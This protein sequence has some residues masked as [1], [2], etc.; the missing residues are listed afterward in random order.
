MRFNTHLDERGKYTQEII[1][2]I[3]ASRNIAHPKTFMNPTKRHLLPLDSLPNVDKA[4]RTIFDGIGKGKRFTVLFDCDLDGVSSGTIITR[5]LRQFGANINTVI[6]PKKLHGVHDINA[7]RD[8]EIL[9]IVDSLDG[10]INN[11]RKLKDLG[12]EII[13]MDHHAVNPEIP[14][15]DVVTLVTSQTTYKN[16]ELSGA[17]VVWKCCKYFDSQ[18]GTD[19]ADAYVD[20][21]ACG[22]VGDMVSMAVM[23]NRYIVKQGISNLNNLAVKKILKS[24]EFNATAISFS[25]APIINASMRV[26]YNQYAMEA[27]LC[28]DPK[29]MR[30]L[31][32]A[33]R[34]GRELQDEEVQRIMPDVMKQCEE[35]I[36]RKMMTIIIKSEYGIS[37]LIGNKLLPI[38][39]RPILILQEEKDFYR[40]SMR[41]MGTDDFRKFLNDSGLASA[42][43]HELASGIKIEREN[44]KPLLDYVEDN[45]VID[46]GEITVDADIQLGLEDLSLD[47]YDEIHKIDMVSGS[48]FT[49]ITAYV[50]GV[51]NYDIS[52]L[53]NGKHLVITPAGDNVQFVYWNKGDLEEEYLDHALYGDELRL[54]GTISKSFYPHTMTQIVIRELEAVA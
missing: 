23:E 33:L 48:G 54:V 5:Y 35:Q 43:G 38:Y 24:Y 46:V 40:G 22:L 39:K 21:A 7:L 6:N 19:Y 13:V 29:Q 3:F 18:E 44:L 51:K 45:F 10:T 53:S 12:I 32:K 41:A 9:I 15:D 20:L 1:E 14:Y 34:S 4:Y 50:E 16:H 37:G 47:L 42:E 28:D 52:T 8:C 17:G 2:D 31:M 11:Y 27:F 25:V 49:P 30:G 26:N 36:D